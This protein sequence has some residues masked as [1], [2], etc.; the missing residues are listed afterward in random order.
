MSKYKLI[1]I[2]AALSVVTGI[3]WFAIR[4]DS[5]PPEPIYGG[6]NLSVWLSNESIDRAM[7]NG[8]GLTD[9]A[10]Q[11]VRAI[12][13]NAIPYL[14][15]TL[16][17]PGT[18][19]DSIMKRHRA[20]TGFRALGSEASPAYPKLVSLVLTSPN[21]FVRDA[22]INSLMVADRDAVA[23]LTQALQSQDQQTRA[24]AAFA[25]RADRG[26]PD[27]A[28][29]SLSEALNDPNSE[30]RANAVEALGAY[31][32]GG[33]HQVLAHSLVPKITALLRDTNGRVRNSAAEALREINLK[34][35]TP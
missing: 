21:S 34:P 7:V 9:D 35:A 5:L 13:T 20:A 1:L 33:S 32:W 2:V 28:I 15:A 24:L 18:N 30:V 4:R 23:L 3:F 12:G 10:V 19:G 11:A 6:K 25:L 27:I 29:P 8:I 16:Q 14:L 22:A 17:C 31:L 26:A